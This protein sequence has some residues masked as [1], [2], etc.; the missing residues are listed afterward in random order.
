M[1][2]RLVGVLLAMMLSIPLFAGENRWSSFPIRASDLI[3]DPQDPNTIYAFNSGGLSYST[4]R[5]S[6]WTT[7]A[8]EGLVEDGSSFWNAAIAYASPGTF[9]IAINTGVY[10]TRDRGEHWANIGAPPL[11]YGVVLDPSDADRIF[12]NVNGECSPVFCVSHGYRSTDG[13]STWAPL[14]SVDGRPAV[15]VL[16]TPSDPEWLFGAYG[17]VVSS[18]LRG[19]PADALSAIGYVPFLTQLVANRLDPRILYGVGF[20]FLGDPS[21][22][23]YRSD[24]S[25]I[26]WVHRSEIA[27]LGLLAANPSDPRKLAMSSRLHGLLISD[28][29]GLSWVL[30]QGLNDKNISSVEFSSD[31]QTLYAAGQDAIHQYTFCGDCRPLVPGERRRPDRVGPRA[32]LP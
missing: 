21:P 30:F 7:P 25:G 14:L 26:S 24:D 15:A 31:G 2:S 17:D 9:Y 5:G 22:G 12:V 13:G 10:R 18:F 1:R 32:S 19:D 4:D 8:N 6:S 11:A 20:D 23:F 16:V 27:D 29:E 28:D 3:A